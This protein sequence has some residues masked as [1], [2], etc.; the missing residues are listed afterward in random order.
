[1]PL[2]PDQ[3][4]RKWCGWKPD[5]A[6]YFDNLDGC[7]YFECAVRERGLFADYAD[8]LEMAVDTNNVPERMTFREYAFLTATAEQ[9]AEAILRVIEQQEG[10]GG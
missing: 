2:T 4:I 3:R 10:Q 8:A 5:G 1:M 9:R 7:R 6:I